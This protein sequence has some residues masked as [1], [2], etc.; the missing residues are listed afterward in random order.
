[1]ENPGELKRL[2][3]HSSW[4]IIHRKKRFQMKHSHLNYPCLAGVFKKKIISR[5]LLKKI[6]LKSSFSGK[7]AK[8]KNLHMFF[9]LPCWSIIPSWL[10]FLCSL[11]SLPKIYIEQRSSFIS[12]ISLKFKTNVNV[13]KRI[14]F[15]WPS[16]K[17]I[18]LD[19]QRYPFKR[20][21][22]MR[23]LGFFSFYCLFSF[24]VYLRK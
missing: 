19:L 24:V 14:M 13:I 7:F 1:M 20:C 12:L 8:H 22:F 2:N 11:F 23:Y 6:Y 21:L 16:K 18:M 15:K 9:L 4:T 10:S 3:L 5:K 17:K